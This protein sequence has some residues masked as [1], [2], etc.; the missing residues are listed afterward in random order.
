MKNLCK[1]KQNSE[2]STWID[3]GR[4]SDRNSSTRNYLVADFSFI[5][6]FAQ[7]SVQAQILYSRRWMRPVSIHFFYSFTCTDLDATI[8]GN[9]VTSKLSVTPDMFS[10]IA[11]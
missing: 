7:I 9:K 6:I 4:E 2:I 3:A 8:L 10:L 5:F 1:K 11:S